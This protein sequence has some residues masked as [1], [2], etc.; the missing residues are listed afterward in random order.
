MRKKPSLILQLFLKLFLIFITLIAVLGFSTYKYAEEVI[1]KEVV[2][3]NSNMLQQIAIRIAQEMQDIEDLASRIAYDPEILDLLEKRSRGVSLNKE[4]IQ[5][6][7]GIMA[8][9]I[10]SYRDTAMLIDVHLIDNQSDTYSTS[11][12]MSSNP[13]TDLAIYSKVLKNRS[14]SVIFPVKT[15]QNSSG[16]TNYFFQVAR[17]VKDYVSRQNYGLLL[18]NVDEKLLSYNYIRLTNEEKDFCIVDENGVV[19]SHKDKSQIGKNLFNFTE[20]TDLSKP[21]NYILSWDKIHI[22]QRINKSGWYLVESIA[23]ES[24]MLPLQK[25]EWFLIIFGILCILITTVVLYLTAKKIAGPLNLLTD[26]MTEFN[27]GNLDIKIPDSRYREFSEITL[28]F[29]EL[30]HQV[31]YLLAENTKNERQ[32]RLLELDFLQAQINPHFIHNTLSSIRFYVDMG[33]NR[34]AEEM[35]YYFS[36]LLRRVLSR[37]DEFVK[38]SE[39]VKHLEDYIALQ[40]MRYGDAFTV[41]FILSEEAQEAQIPSF[42]L[43]PLVENAIFHGLQ[44]GRLIEIKIEAYKVDHDLYLTVSDNGVGISQEKIAEI[45]SKKVQMNKVGI[46]NVHE[47]I[48]I[49][50]GNSYGLTIEQNKPVGSK[51]ILKLRYHV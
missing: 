44:A 19:L 34:E 45:F 12:S 8:S 47:R 28:T 26:K 41:Q 5:K 6:L 23:L 27:Q 35:L 40:K 33:K 21:N 1:E 51:I 22:F 32:K 13:E 2:Q 39:E 16:K 29:N 48:R 10:W 15:S 24:A 9:Y 11:Y 38:L 14:D 49:L 18:L 7:E 43:Q 50:Y 4:Q 3:L 25:I 37:S 36:K 17:N 42:I 20:D 30:I 31:N 46:L